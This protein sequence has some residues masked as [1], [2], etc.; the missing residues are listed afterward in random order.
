[1]ALPSLLKKGRS[2]GVRVGIAFQSISGLRD[3]KLF[4]QQVTDDILGQ[5]SN[6][7]CG[8]VECHETA[9][10][11]SRLMGD[12]EF[13]QVSESRSQ[14]KQRLTTSKNWQP[15]IRRA[16]LPSEFMSIAPCGFKNGLT[17]LFTTRSDLPTWDVLPARLLFNQLL[18]PA[19][20]DVPE[21]IPRDPY[22]QFVQPW[23]PELES[24]FAPRQELRKDNTI[25][26]DGQ[27]LDPENDLDSFDL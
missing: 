16:M 17:G 4:G 25:S 21:F 11:L 8:R 23:T 15:A 2:K 13:R 22:S 9:E 1:M 12:A 26:P 10:F 5:I 14:S 6:R 19:A 18:I 3:P 20:D 27:S 7:F 24:I